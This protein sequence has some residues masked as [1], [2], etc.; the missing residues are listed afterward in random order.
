LRQAVDVEAE[1]SDVEFPAEP[2]VTEKADE[3][4]VHIAGDIGM[5]QGA[6]HPGVADY[7]LN[8][9]AGR[10]ATRPDGNLDPEENP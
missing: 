4:Q 10:G 3:P 9:R 1:W 2:I 8:E 6:A 5:E 7:V